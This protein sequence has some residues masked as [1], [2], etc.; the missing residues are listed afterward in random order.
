PVV[1]GVVTKVA[2]LLDGVG[3]KVTMLGDTLNTTLSTGP[4]S[5]LTNTVGGKLV[6]VIAMVEST[7]DKIG[8]ATGLGT[9][10]KGVISQ[11]GGAVN[12]LGGKVTDAGH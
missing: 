6:P 12:G 7:T 4:T 8:S 5:Q 1:G 2:P 9:P 3:E 11:I 10:L